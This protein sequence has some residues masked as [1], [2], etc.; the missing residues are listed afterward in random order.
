MHLSLFVRSCWINSCFHGDCH[1][2]GTTTTFAT[3]F[4]ILV[5]K[6]AFQNTFQRAFTAYGCFFKEIILVGSNQS[7]YFE[8]ATTCSK[9]TLKTTVEMKL[10]VLLRL[11]KK[12][13]QLKLFLVD[14]DQLLINM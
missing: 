8:N 4:A 7:N 1:S 9:R 10:N 14:W 3:F 13:Y 6:A 12:R 11:K 5:S 2:I